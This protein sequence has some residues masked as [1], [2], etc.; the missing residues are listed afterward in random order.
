[1]FDITQPFNTQVEQAFHWQHQALSLEAFSRT[2]VVGTCGG[3]ALVTQAQWRQP[4]LL[5]IDEMCHRHSGADAEPVTPASRLLAQY[6]LMLVKTR[7]HQSGDDGAAAPYDFSHYQKAIM[8]QQLQWI[9]HWTQVL[10]QH[11]AS[12]EVGEQHLLSLP[13]IRL[14]LARVMQ[15]QAWLQ[16]GIADATH[17]DMPHWCSVYL[18]RLDNLLDDLIKTAGGRALLNHGLVQMQSLFTLINQ[19]Y[20]R[21]RHVP[22]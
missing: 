14:R 21:T 15:H 12:R 3:L 11:A 1:M 19:L 7:P 9:A 16:Q 6:G 13:S 18:S 8:Q 10:T 5:L 22:T 20:L 17:S 2:G 4:D